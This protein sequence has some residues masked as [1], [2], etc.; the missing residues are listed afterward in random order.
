MF[1]EETPQELNFRGKYRKYDPNGYYSVYNTG[2]VVEYLGK[3]YVAVKATKNIIPLNNIT[4]WKELEVASRFFRSEVEPSD[5][6]EGDRWLDITTG[7]VYTR[8]R[9]MNGLHWVEF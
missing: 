9:D 4:N 2:D 3:R 7:I 1:I 5:T 8:I 6:N